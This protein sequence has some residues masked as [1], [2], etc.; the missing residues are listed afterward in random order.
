ML[1]LPFHALLL[2]GC[3]VEFLAVSMFYLTGQYYSF[4]QGYRMSC[5][6]EGSAKKKKEIFGYECDAL[7]LVLNHCDRL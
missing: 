1:M 2:K 5:F 3:E 6:A 4:G 7:S